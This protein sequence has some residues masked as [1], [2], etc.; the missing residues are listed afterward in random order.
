[1]CMPLNKTS[2]VMR[3]LCPGIQ[4]IVFSSVSPWMFLRTSIFELSNLIKSPSNFS[5][6]TT[7]E[8][9]PAQDRFPFIYFLLIDLVDSVHYRRIRNNPHSR[10]CLSKNLQTKKMIGVLMGN[11]DKRQWLFGLFDFLHYPFSI[12]FC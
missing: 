12:G 9:A 7:R 4:S 2:P 10:V 11:V 8:V 1:M 6:A 5:M 3:I